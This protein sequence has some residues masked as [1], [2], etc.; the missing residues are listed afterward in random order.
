MRYKTY[1]DLPFMVD[2]NYLIVAPELEPLCRQYFG[3]EAK[4]LP[5]TD[6]NDENPVYGMKYS[7][8]KALTAKQWIVGD[9][10]L[11]QDHIKQV[12]GTNPMVIPQKSSNPLIQEFVGY[13]DYVM[14]WSETKMIFGSNPA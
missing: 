11:M 5:G 3:K 6:Y 7:V 8:N 9:H 13:M 14:G 12:N 2:F 4:H 1:D 10:L